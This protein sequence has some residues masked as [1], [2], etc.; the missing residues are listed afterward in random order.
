[1]KTLPPR[2]IEL[3]D[4]VLDRCDAVP[5]LIG[6]PRDFLFI[7]GLAGTS[8]DAAS[9]LN[10]GPTHFSMAGTMGAAAMM[11]LGLALAQPE[12]TVIVLTGDAE[13]MMNVGSLATIAVRDPKNLRIICIDNGHFGET[14]YQRS[15]TGYGVDIEKIA[16]GSGIR[17]TTTITHTQEIP[18]GRRMLRETDGTAFILM[19]VRPTPPPQV[20]RLLDPPAQRMRFRQAL[21]G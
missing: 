7:G 13:L 1:M 9:L 16:I 14:G 8:R 2:A 19:R 20:K 12:R 21:L 4:Y 15:H 10:D 17:T 6:D 3:P 11:G 18:V 5:A